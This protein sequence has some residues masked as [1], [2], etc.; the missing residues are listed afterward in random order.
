VHGTVKTSPRKLF[1]RNART[2]ETV[3]ATHS[4]APLLEYAFGEEAFRR[5]GAS[6][7]NSGGQKGKGKRK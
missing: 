1:E 5:I 4:L 6:K 2:N 7:G 3:C